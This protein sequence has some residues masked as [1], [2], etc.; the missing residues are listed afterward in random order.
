MFTHINTIFDIIFMFSLESSYCPVLTASKKR[1][2][3]SVILLTAVSF[4][5]YYIFFWVIFS[6]SFP[7][8]LFL[9]I[10]LGLLLLPLAKSKANA[11]IIVLF[12]VI[13]NA[14]IRFCLD[15]FFAKLGTLQGSRTLRSYIISNI[16]ILFL[17]FLYTR[18]LQ[19][20][21]KA[22]SDFIPLYYQLVFIGLLC[23]LFGFLYLPGT[24]T[25]S[26]ILLYVYMLFL[27]LIILAL[28]ILLESISRDMKQQLQTIFTLREENLKASHISDIQYLYQKLRVLRHEQKNSLFYI[29]TL[30]ELKDYD[31]LQNYAEK[32]TDTEQ[33][34]LS[35]IDTGNIMVNAILQPFMTKAAEDHIEVSVTASLPEKLEISDG[36]LISLL[37]NLLDNARENLDPEHPRINVKLRILKGY[38]SII[39][40]NSVAD[41]VLEKNPRLHTTKE[42]ADLHGIGT[43]V[44]RSIVDEYGGN[45][46]YNCTED[47]FTAN[48]LIPQQ[49][50]P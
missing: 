35:A 49:M 28:Y 27:F 2:V 33:A 24:L 1:Q 46:K 6:H 48:I 31:R 12:S 25:D 42:K 45:I 43:Q 41:N 26:G 23:L 29:R 37:S 10:V 19:K 32:L 8:Y 7:E 50:I 47:T 15:V 4:V 13:G 16:L 39:V 9:Y 40:E 36:P 3:L 17:L 44:V 11:L 21:S 22:A 14:Y 38:L 20:H 34:Y 18:M 30:L 5:L